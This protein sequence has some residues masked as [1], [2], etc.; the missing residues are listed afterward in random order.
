MRPEHAQQIE[1]TDRN[2]GESKEREG[3]GRV[4]YEEIESDV[5][6][7][8]SGQC[9][10]DICFFS[11]FDDPS[12]QTIRPYRSDDRDQAYTTKVNTPAP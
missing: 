8:F 3:Q 2:G 11:H 10:W 5:C 6:G 1:T 4:G 12:T 9:C 7:H